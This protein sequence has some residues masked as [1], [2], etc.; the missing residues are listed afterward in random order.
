MITINPIFPCKSPVSWVGNKSPILGIILALMPLDCPR[1]VD[2][3]GGS[4]SVTLGKPPGN[5]FEVYND[6]DGNLVNLF[7]LMKKRPLS[8]IREL[9][10]LT[11]NSRDDFIVL[12]RFINQEEFNDEFLEKEMQLTQITLPPLEA[13]EIS[14]L[15]LDK[16]K[17]YEVIRACNY[18]KLLRYSYS[19]GGKSF[20]SQPFDI[21][22]LFY[23]IWQTHAR[24]S[25]VVIEN[26]DF[27]KLIKHYDR[28]NTVFYLDPP[29]Y[30]TEDMY[31]QAFTKEDHYRLFET[32]KSAKGKWLL[33]Y[34]DCEFIRDLYRDYFI[35]EF[36][37]VH[38]MAQRYEAGKQ[39]PELLIGNYDLYE[40]ER[41]K[42]CQMTLFGH[43]EFDYE[44]ILKE[45]IL[46]CKIRL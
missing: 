4:G 28:E 15:M 20:A 45:C 32:L 35:F 36:S 10:F 6:F 41:N 43:E 46:Q 14:Q 25:N 23:L 5:D 40:R 24:L 26:Q 11:L 34:N 30:Q 21:R 37:R 44:K 7:R 33:S 16:A 2:V 17:D 31:A 38:S 27:E 13:D 12:R 42:P 39:F 22:K 19:S 1:F 8:V 29:Y 18:L 9:G 3:F